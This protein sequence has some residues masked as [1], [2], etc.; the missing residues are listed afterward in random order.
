M[1]N[2]PPRSARTPDGPLGGFK[3]RAELMEGPPAT[4]RL[5]ESEG[6][7]NSSA[8][9]GAHYSLEF[10]K[11]TSSAL[12]F[13]KKS[14]VSGESPDSLPLEEAGSAGS[15]G[16]C[17]PDARAISGHLGHSKSELQLTT[18]L[19]RRAEED[20]QRL[21]N[22]VALLR[23]SELKTV[24]KIRETESEAQRLELRKIQN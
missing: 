14:L 22:R 18:E 4:A 9:G 11:Q 15:A 8:E 10:S 5:A 20:A 17:S 23:I 3:R 1:R 19:R 24:R 13:T 2:S 7:L 21:A 16:S 6:G 12:Q